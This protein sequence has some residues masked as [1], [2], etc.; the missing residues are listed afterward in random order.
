M[1]ILETW[2]KEKGLITITMAAE[3]VDVSQSAISQAADRGKIQSFTLKKKRYLS[4]SD[5]LKY[6]AIKKESEKNK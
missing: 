6:S 2:E 4:F 3:I 1:N 5:V